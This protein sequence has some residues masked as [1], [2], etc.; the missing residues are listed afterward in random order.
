VPGTKFPAGFGHIAGHYGAG[1]YGYLWSL[2]LAMDM[3]T[4]FGNNKLDPLVGRRY[5][6]AVLANG[7][8]F[9]PDELLRRFL[10][11]AANSKAFFDDLRQ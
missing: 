10:G 11:R 4:A 8:Q 6:D 7:S 1:Y 9:P 5:R 2:V 3:R